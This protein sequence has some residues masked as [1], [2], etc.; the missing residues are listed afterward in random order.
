[1]VGTVS[2]VMAVPF[3]VFAATPTLALALPTQGQN[4]VPVTA[5]TN[6]NGGIYITRPEGASY[7][8]MNGV[9]NAGHGIKHYTYVCLSTTTY[10]VSWKPAPKVFT[11]LQCSELIVTTDGTSYVCTDT[12]ITLPQSGITMTAVAVHPKTIRLN[13]QGANKEKLGVAVNKTKWIHA[14]NDSKMKVGV[15]YLGLDASGKAVIHVVITTKPVEKP[16]MHAPTAWINVQ[17]KQDVNTG[18]SYTLNLG[19]YDTSS[20][21]KMILSGGLSTET[22][23]PH[24]K[25]WEYTSSAHAVQESFTLPFTLEYG[26]TYKFQLAGWDTA[27]NASTVAVLLVNVPADSQIDSVAPS[28][29]FQNMTSTNVNTGYTYT[30]NITAKDMDSAISKIVLYGLQTDLSQPIEFLKEWTF[31]TGTQK[32][33]TVSYTTKTIP[34][35]KTYRLYA[36]AWDASGNVSGFYI[37]N[38][39][40][41]MMNDTQNPIITTQMTSKV[42]QSGNVYTLVPVFSAKATDNSNML[43]EVVIYYST[44]STAST[45]SVAK[46]C[47]E[48][49]QNT[50]CTYEGTQ[51]Q[52]DGYFYAKAWDKAGNTAT[53]EMTSLKGQLL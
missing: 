7:P 37:F 24:I 33:V 9:K 30:V 27:G 40:P 21:Q 26:K 18:Y 46:T 42:V 1:M 14:K 5:C 44:S 19:S 50:W 34:Y 49:S 6:I 51:T 31:P 43:D 17:S 20:I 15:R 13:L 11:P 3:T 23:L 10:S 29:S 8:L 39:A 32:E 28:V 22:S 41:A 45:F 38:G 47:D 16:D 48:I 53:S 52:D 35:G 12:V 25:T 2:L 36:Q 4:V